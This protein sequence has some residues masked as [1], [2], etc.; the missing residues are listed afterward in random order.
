MQASIGR[1]FGE[2]PCL[3]QSTD[4]KIILRRII[5]K[6]DNSTNMKLIPWVQSWTQ[7]LQFVF[8]LVSKA[9]EQWRDTTCN[10]MFFKLSSCRSLT[11]ILLE[12]EWQTRLVH[13]PIWCRNTQLPQTQTI[14]AFTIITIITVVICLTQKSYSM[15][16]SNRI[17]DEQLTTRP[18]SS[19]HSMLHDVAE[20]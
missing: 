18:K 11:S 6:N 13:Q 3:Q 17:Y 10:F 19:Y 2:M 14:L 8:L 1:T 7:H 12:D 20:P 4:E 15:Y 9:E 5:T 16:N